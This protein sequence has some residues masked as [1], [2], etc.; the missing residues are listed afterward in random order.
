MEEF[1]DTRHKKPRRLSE[2][3]R[4][5]IASAF[6]RRFAAITTNA[7]V[8]ENMLD[9]ESDL[10]IDDLTSVESDPAE[11]AEADERGWVKLNSP[12]GEFF[13]E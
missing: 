5:R 12:Q 11:F 8:L 1:A 6:M 7:Q 3:S 13:A 9:E 2:K 10:L 4:R